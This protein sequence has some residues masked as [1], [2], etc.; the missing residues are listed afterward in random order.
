MDNLKKII[1]QDLSDQRIN[2]KIIVPICY[3]D[4]GLFD[5]HYDNMIK[6]E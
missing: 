1:I 5:I 3:I 4:Y 6:E 2:D